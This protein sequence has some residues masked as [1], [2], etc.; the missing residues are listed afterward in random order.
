MLCLKV[1]L[2]FPYSLFFRV[3]SVCGSAWGLE[4]AQGKKLV[5]KDMEEGVEYVRQRHQSSKAM[6]DGVAMGR[7][8]ELC[9]LISATLYLI[10]APP[11]VH[12]AFYS[13]HF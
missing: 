10:R 11:P 1:A 3:R 4:I 12:K 5:K 13:K 2:P 9:C 6:T 7:E 8:G